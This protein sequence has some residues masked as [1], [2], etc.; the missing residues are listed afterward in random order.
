MNESR[1]QKSIMN[2]K[3]N[4]V[5][6][7]IMLFLTFFSR[8]VF[9]D[10]L[11]AEF[12]GLSGT[13]QNILQMLSLA[14]LGVGA[15]ISFHLYKPIREED[16][17]K[18]N[19]LTSL[20]GWFYRI[21]GGFILL[22]SIIVSC[23][24]PYIF[25]H[26]TIEIFVVYFVFYCFLSS[27]LIGYFIN[28]RQLLLTADQRNYVVSI[29]IQ[30]GQVIK[31][32]LQMALCIYYCNYYL[33]AVVEFFFSVIS[34]LILN[35]RINHTYP[36]LKSQPQL[37]FSLYKQYPSVIRSTKQIFI[38]RIKDFL[39]KQSDQILVFAFV[40]LKMVAYYN[41]YSMLIARVTMLC[42]SVLDSASAGVGNLVAEGKKDK[43]VKVFWELMSA[44]YWAAGLLSSFLYFTI[45]PFIINWLGEEYLLSE[46]ITALLCINMF[47]MLSRTTVD[48]FNHAYGLYG[49]IWAAWAE[50]IINLAV[51]ITVA[52][53]F[54]IIGILLGKIVSL[55]VIVIIWKPL[56]LYRKGLY[57][58][59]LQYWRNTIVYYGLLFISLCIAY[60]AIHLVPM[61]PAVSWS[62][63]IIF[64]CYIGLVITITYSTLMYYI[65]IGTKDF[66]NTMIRHLRHK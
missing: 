54:G 33:W 31:V 47:I 13:L 44:R 18:I 64:S 6:Y 43:I 48:N 55:F 51:T 46:T 63:F 53:K 16:Y 7:F 1:V 41:N 27:S 3:V 58:K 57:L 20:F 36:W 66:V 40:S 37:G 23:L 50:G 17:G 60:I 10:T 45:P 11:G 62:H 30:G 65:G 26:T 29:Y 34:C 5:F 59:Y 35:N 9:L 12:I 32:I 42:T 52:L 38:H 28:Y 22:I 21:V 2:A 19:Q 39:L 24:F 61:R 25:D 15:S 49:D 56:Y 8:K 4:F 14:E